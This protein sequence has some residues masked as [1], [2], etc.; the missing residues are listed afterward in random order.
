MLVCCPL[1]SVEGAQTDRPPAIL[2]LNKIKNYM[3]NIKSVVVG[4]IRFSLCIANTNIYLMQTVLLERRNANVN[5]L[6]GF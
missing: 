3:Q 2:R 4:G 6:L 1:E 5:A